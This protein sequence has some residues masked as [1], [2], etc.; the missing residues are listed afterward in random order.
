MQ[1][2]NK[3]HYTRVHFFMKIQIYHHYLKIINELILIIMS[4]IIA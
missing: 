1:K 4:L 2:M 3:N